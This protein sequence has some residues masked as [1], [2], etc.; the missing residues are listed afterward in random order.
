[1]NLYV[2]SSVLLRLVLGE[3]GRLRQWKAVKKAVS[4]EIIR[5]ECLRTLDRARLRLGRP[6]EEVAQKRVEVRRRL[7]AF[8]LVRLDDV[9]LERA[10]DPFPTLV[11]SLDAIHLASAIL[12][13]TRIPDIVFA[14][15]DQQLEMAA[16]ACGFAVVGV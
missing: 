16:R 9:V 10:A 2:D 3:A 14:T 8:D 4:S 15:H 12:V 11:G 7:E 6:D 5:L 13:R 1:M